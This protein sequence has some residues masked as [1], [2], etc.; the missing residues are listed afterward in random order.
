MMK[1]IDFKRL[2]PL[3]LALFMGCIALGCGEDAALTA[4]DGLEAED[5]LQ[6]ECARPFDPLNPGLRMTYVDFSAPASLDNPVIEAFVN[7]SFMAE[8]CLWLFQFT[9][10]DNGSFD[11]DGRLQVLTGAGEKVEAVAGCYAFADASGYPSA[12]IE[13]NGTGDSIVGPDDAGSVDLTVPVY[14]SNPEAGTRDLVARFPMKRFSIESGTFAPDRAAMGTEAE[15]GGVFTA[16]I[17]VEDAREVVIEQMGCT[18][19]GL[20]SGDRGGDP[21]DPDDDCLQDDQA[22]IHPPDMEHKGKPA[23]EVR[24]CFSAVAISIL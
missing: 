8:D 19:C 6:E 9:D 13:M 24:A 22:W 17:T 11:S 1:V 14:V 21:E 10:V 2:F 12:E 16:L 18:L 23:F 15:C 4:P 7:E 3:A 20:L 5:A